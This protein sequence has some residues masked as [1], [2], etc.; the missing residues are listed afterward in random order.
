MKAS[1]SMKDKRISNEEYAGTLITVAVV[2][3]IVMLAIFAGG[4]YA[5]TQIFDLQWYW[6]V[7]LFLLFVAIWTRKPK[8]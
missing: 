6:G 7:V 4:A 8:K 5:I 1:K 2:V 3:T